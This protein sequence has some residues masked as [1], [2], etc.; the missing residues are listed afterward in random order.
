MQKYLPTTVGSKSTITA[1]GTIF[2]LL[3]SLKNVLKQSLEYVIFLSGGILPSG[4]IPC[5]KQYNSQQEFPIWTP[6]WPTCTD[7]HSRYHENSLTIKI[8]VF[9]YFFFY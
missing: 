9:F 7:I 6:A 5:S 3:V 8:H 2:P 1:R 4:S